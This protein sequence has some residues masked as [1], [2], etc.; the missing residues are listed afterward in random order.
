MDPRFLSGSFVNNRGWQ[1]QYDTFYIE[2][3]REA[4]ASLIFVPFILLGYHPILGYL[5]VLYL[6]F[7]LA[8]WFFCKSLKFDVLL[9]Y[10]LMLSP[11]F[12]YLS[13]MVN[14]TEILSLSLL[15]IAIGFIF[16]KSSF[17]GIFIGA[18]GLA[19]Y[20]ILI[21]LPLLLFLGD[22]KKIAVSYLLFALTTLPWLAF[23][24]IFYG[25]LLEAYIGSITLNVTNNPSF[26][27][28]IIPILLSFAIPAFV[29]AVGLLYVKAGGRK[30][31][32]SIASALRESSFTRFALV[33]LVLA[34]AAYVVMAKSSGF[35]DQVRYAYCLYG[36]GAFF[37]LIILQHEI[38]S[39]KNLGKVVALTAI[40]I[41]SISPVTYYA[42]T[43]DYSSAGNV[44][45]RN[46][47]VK[48]SIVELGAMGYANCRVESNAWVY[49]LYLNVSAYSPL[50][51]NATV[52]SEYPIVVFGS[53][54]ISPS[55]DWNTNGSKLVYEGDG[56]SVFLPSN[57][58]CVR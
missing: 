36:A 25:N 51:L 48:A 33:F 37:A 42:I 31:K 13:L 56:F 44:N 47:T 15:L 29:L 34:L 10:G 7:A 40:V 28:P 11:F 20:P 38:R 32:G 54:G 24:Y 39:V 41:L 4:I 12:V 22:K 26:S 53:F 23:N 50:Y 17:A 46:S 1:I 19:K 2:P 43:R 16:R 30:L 5:I 57:V 35:F 49:L 3:Y 52:A 58:M 6:L 18:A 55:Y 14:G 27:I 8:I 21:F 9:G 45:S